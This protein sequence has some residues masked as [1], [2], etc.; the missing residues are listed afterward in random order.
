MTGEATGTGNGAVLGSR[1]VLHPEKMR[2]DKSVPGDV[3]QDRRFERLSV[4]GDRHGGHNGGYGRSSSQEKKGAEE[5]RTGIWKGEKRRGKKKYYFSPRSRP[6]R[7]AKE[8]VPD[9]E[10]TDSRME[11]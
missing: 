1:E 10:N 7:R 5:I 3:R 2:R 8:G 11:A 4:P 9:R 6:S